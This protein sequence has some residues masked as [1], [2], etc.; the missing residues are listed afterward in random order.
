MAGLTG[1]LDKLE[2]HSRRNNLRRNGISGGI[3]EQWSDC[4]NK[5]RDFIKNDL[6]LPEKENVKI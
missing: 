4:E 3:N 5:V 1:Q 6:N 2:G